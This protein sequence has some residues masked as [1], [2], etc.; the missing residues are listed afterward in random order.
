MKDYQQDQEADFELGATTS[1]VRISLDSK[2]Y[3]NDNQV[4]IAIADIESYDFEENIH[5]SFTCS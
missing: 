2:V 5:G 1:R 4:V 3:A